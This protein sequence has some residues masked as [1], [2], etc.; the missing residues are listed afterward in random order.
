MPG[1]QP[2]RPEGWQAAL[3][4][5]ADGS[6]WQ[7]QLAM[8]ACTPACWS[9]NSSVAS[10]VALADAVGQVDEAVGS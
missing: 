9:A 10:P 4:G 7:L 3:A 6:C 8:Q 5:S 2:P 1:L